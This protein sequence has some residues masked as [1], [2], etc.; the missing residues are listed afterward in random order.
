M[1]TTEPTSAAA[2]PMIQLPPGVTIGPGRETSQS[3]PITQAIV[4]GMVF[5][6]TLTNGTTTSVFIPYDVLQHQPDQARQLI[7]DRV[8]AITAIT[9]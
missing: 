4:Q 2:G 8:N 9:D 7:V 3:S 1:S 6:L 5:P